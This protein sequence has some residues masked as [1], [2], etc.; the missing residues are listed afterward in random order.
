[1]AK[2]TQLITDL[3]KLDRG[4]NF[5]SMVSKSMRGL[6]QLQDLVVEDVQE[7]TQVAR[8]EPNEGPRD[9]LQGGS[10]GMPDERLSLYKPMRKGSLRLVESDLSAKD[11]DVTQDPESL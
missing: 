3:K 8:T 5:G 4:E 11:K 1:M 7:L 6:A 10:V 2:S 9:Q